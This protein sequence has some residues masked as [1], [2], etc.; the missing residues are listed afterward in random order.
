MWSCDPLH[1]LRRLTPNDC[2]LLSNPIHSSTE[3]LHHSLPAA[4]AE[5]S[6]SIASASASE[7]DSNS[8]IVPQP[9]AWSALG[10]ITNAPIAAEQPEPGDLDP[11][12]SESGSGSCQAEPEGKEVV[13]RRCSS[14]WTAETRWQCGSCKPSRHSGNTGSSTGT[15][16]RWGGQHR[17]LQHRQQ[18]RN[19]EKVRTAT[20]A[21]ATQNYEKV[22]TRGIVA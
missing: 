12:Q 1:K 14:R 22:R 11:L 7:P 15:V 4:D 3:T 17:Q 8:N 2:C 5:S 6:A 21:E 19:C 20:Q 13:A 16:R 10:P 9:P 18:H